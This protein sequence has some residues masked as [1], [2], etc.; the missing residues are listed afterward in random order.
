[1]TRSCKKRFER[2]NLRG[3]RRAG[4]MLLPKLL[5]AA[6]CV[7]RAPRVCLSSANDL[8]TALVDEIGAGADTTTTLEALEAVGGFDGE[9]SGRWK[10]LSF[11]KLQ[12][13]LEELDTTVL[14]LCELRVSD[15]G[16]EFMQNELHLSF[17]LS[18]GDSAPVRVTCSGVVS[19]RDDDIGVVLLRAIMLPVSEDSD[20][21]SGFDAVEEALSPHLPPGAI[22]ARLPLIHLD[23]TICA[24]KDGA[25]GVVVL[26]REEAVEDVEADVFGEK[27]G[28]A[29]QAAAFA[30]AEASEAGS[31]GADGSAGAV[32]DAVV[33]SARDVYLGAEG[34][35]F[36]EEEED[37]RGREL[38][39]GSP[40]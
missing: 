29:L 34:D 23:E 2:C 17:V 32:V 21:E 6:T 25:G 38:W 35:D 13:R 11:N 12:S 31:A 19:F 33:S 24:L 9:P 16:P 14:S 28:P 20:D 18:A 15:D 7:S 10:A 26:Q 39:V 37:E 27:A 22:R 1:M 36:G 5:V 30:A 40:Y 8:V 4:G 3:A